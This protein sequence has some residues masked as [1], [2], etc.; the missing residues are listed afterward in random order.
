M[1]YLS[2][3]V[4]AETEN[5]ACPPPVV[6]PDGWRDE[7]RPAATLPR[8]DELLELAGSAARRVSSW[9]YGVP[10]SERRYELLE[11]TVTREVWLIHWPTGRGLSLHDH[12]GSSGAFYLVAGELEETVPARRSARLHHHI[13]RAGT[14]SSFG[15]AH[16]HSVVNHGN[17]PATSVHVYSPP[18]SSMT[19]YRP[20]RG[21]LVVDRTETEWVG[22]P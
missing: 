1:P 8:S 5:A 7:E 2:P 12:G 4:A 20:S 9:P 21:A 16:I 13:L 14:G 18:L 6:L 10:L 3:L 22:A 19:F 17:D 11:R 15:P